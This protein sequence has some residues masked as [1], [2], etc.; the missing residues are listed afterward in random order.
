MILSSK[1]IFVGNLTPF[2]LCSCY[3]FYTSFRMEFSHWACQGVCECYLSSCPSSP[4]L[5]II[6]DCL[7]VA[8]VM[9]FRLKSRC[10]NSLMDFQPNV[11]VKLSLDSFRLVFLHILFFNKRLAWSLNISNIFLTLKIWLM[12]SFYSIWLHP[13]ICSLHFLCH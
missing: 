1:R 13:T 8:S 7:C 5:S 12:V 3:A 6:N 2:K 9:S 11:Y 10:S 4:S